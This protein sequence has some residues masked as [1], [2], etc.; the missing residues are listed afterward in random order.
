MNKPA[1]SSDTHAP[2]G[3]ATSVPELQAIRV[4]QGI[5]S[6]QRTQVAYCT[7]YYECRRSDSTKHV[8]QMLGTGVIS[9][10]E[11][12]TMLAL[13]SRIVK[14][15][16]GRWTELY[17][18]PLLEEETSLR[19][20]N[21]FVFPT[22]S[23]VMTIAQWYQFYSAP[24]YHSTYIVLPK[25][26]Q[27][28]NKAN[29]KP[30]GFSVELYIN[31]AQY[32]DRTEDPE[33]IAG[34]KAGSKRKASATRSAS[35]PKPPKRTRETISQPSTQTLRSSFVSDG[36]NLLA[37]TPPTLSVTE[38]CFRK[39]TCVVSDDTVTPTLMEETS[40]MSGFL[41]TRTL[42]LSACER[43][44]TKDVFGLQI[45]GQAYVAKKLVNV[46][47]G[48]SEHIP[49]SQAVNALTADL[50]RLKRMA[51]FDKKFKLLALEEGINVAEFDVSDGFLIKIYKGSTTQTEDIG[52]EEQIEEGGP[53]EDLDASSEVTEVYL[54]EPRRL[55]S[56][57][58]KFSGTLG[59]TSRSDLRSLT[60]AAFAHF[61]AEQT[62]C[63]YIF[64][65]IQ[66]SQ[67]AGHPR[68]HPDA[69][70]S[71]PSSS[72][73]T[74]LCNNTNSAFMQAFPAEQWTTTVS[75]VRLLSNV[76]ACAPNLQKPTRKRPLSCRRCASFVL[77]R[78]AEHCIMVAR[79]DKV[80]PSA[81]PQTTSVLDAD[82][83]P[84]RPRPHRPLR[85]G[86]DGPPRRSEDP[87]LAAADLNLRPQS[88]LNAT[89]DLGDVSSSF[90]SL[91]QNMIP[92]TVDPSQ[93][94]DPQLILDFDPPILGRVGPPHRICIHSLLS[95][96]RHLILCTHPASH[97]P[98][99]RVSICLVHP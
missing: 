13:W 20:P 87:V 25:H 91:P 46:G 64:A 79:D 99:Y 51:Y 86:R 85:T 18:A 82:R 35:A 67:R 34:G 17:S 55:T 62:A 10:P 66:V 23:L 88:S 94:I 3:T 24:E 54:V 33:L 14:E 26:A 52:V 96:L 4:A 27:R 68:P 72:A 95:R 29:S 80:C 31:V 15:V 73:L 22:D 65:D 37:H 90:A 97:A 92:A 45:N 6:S 98:Q 75:T 81:L 2:V 93:P 9:F 32:L 11:N 84:R 70:P 36:N 42:D 21:N 7:V 77:R 5:G 28:K 69:T 38:I 63:Q 8:D 47:G 16:N 83:M 58:V 49:I 50:I 74:P 59:A 78:G 48:R 56:T 60:M 41:E 57:V 61:I 76:L 19:A 1:T 44:N 53:R 12:Q 43:G 71:A 89:Q 40:L 30:Y 39:T